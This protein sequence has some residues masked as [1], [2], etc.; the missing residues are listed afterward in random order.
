MDLISLGLQGQRLGLERGFCITN[1]NC[2]TTGFCVALKP[3][4]E[5]FGLEKIQVVTLQSVSGAGYPGQ[6]SLDVLDNVVPWI[7]GEEDK[8]Q[9]EPL[10]IM[11]PLSGKLSPTVLGLIIEK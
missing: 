4:M 2:S 10:K 8:L 9:N 7:S 3:L 11:A 5:K 6:P 1:A